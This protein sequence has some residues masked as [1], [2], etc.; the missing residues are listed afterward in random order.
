MK[1]FWKNTQLLK[2]PLKK[3]KKESGRETH[4]HTHISMTDKSNHRWTGFINPAR[5]RKC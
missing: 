2:L 4:T 3:K 5:W 1:T